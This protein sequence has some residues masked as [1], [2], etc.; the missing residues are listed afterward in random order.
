LTPKAFGRSQNINASSKLNDIAAVSSTGA[1][2][3][4]YFMA[5]SVGVMNDG[6]K[7]ESLT[8]WFLP[9]TGGVFTN[10]I[11]ELEYLAGNNTVLTNGNSLAIVIGSTE[12]STEGAG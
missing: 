9:T 8:K 4:F 3:D 2:N 1:S 5:T 6:S 7:D 11:S 10:L 12:S